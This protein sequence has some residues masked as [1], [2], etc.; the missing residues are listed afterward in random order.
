MTRERIED[1]REIVL[2]FVKK[3]LLETNYEGLGKSDAEMFAKDFD[4]ILNLAIKALEQEP[5]TK[6]DLEVQKAIEIIKAD[7][8]ASYS[9]N[10]I[11][12]A[13]DLAVEALKQTTTIKN[14]L[15][16]DCIDRVQAQTEIEMNALRYTLAKERG[17]MGQVEWSD[18]LIKISDAVDIIRHLP[19]VTPQEPCEDTVKRDDVVRIVQHNNSVN[20]LK[21]IRALPPVTPQEPR[22]IP[23]SERLPK[24]RREVLV[25]AYW[26]ETYQVMMASYFGDGLWW[27]V[28]F[29]NCGDHVQRLKPKAWMPLPSA[30]KGGNHFT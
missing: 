19:S 3:R 6:N 18:Q 8:L 17:G 26:H 11:L 28:P 16:V 24:D 12:L 15:G 23:I 22:W 25:T 21:K 10:E 29:N 2:P 7:S 14:D 9:V 27:C 30:Y 4:E 13:R 5:T 1:F 20:A